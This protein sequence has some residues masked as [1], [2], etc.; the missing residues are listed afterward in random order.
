[1]EDVWKINVFVHLIINLKIQLANPFVH[2]KMVTIVSMEIVLH[3]IFVNVMRDS[4]FWIVGI[5]LACPCVNS[6]A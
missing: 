2:L 1:M 3:P 6:P 5:A 4:S